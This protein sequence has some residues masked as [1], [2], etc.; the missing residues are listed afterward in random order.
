MKKKTFISSVVFILFFCII[1]YACRKFYLDFVHTCKIGENIQTVQDL[2]L[3]LQDIPSSATNISYVAIPS[4]RTIH[5]KNVSNFELSLLS[6]TCE[7]NVSEKSFLEWTKSK[8]IPLQKV[9]GSV[10]IYRYQ[11]NLILPPEG[12]DPDK[13]REYES[14]I[15]ATVHKGYEYSHVL[16]DGDNWNIVYDSENQKAY[17]HLVNSLI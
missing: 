10:T 8:G 4:E 3:W 13:Q 5:K 12:D 17:I 11:Q 15:E 6:V 1:F 16:E 7:F 14:Q 2:P 9:N